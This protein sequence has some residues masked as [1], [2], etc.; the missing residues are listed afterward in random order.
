MRKIY[1]FL[2][3]FVYL[4]ASVSA[5]TIDEFN[6]NIEVYQDGMVK[7]NNKL[8]FDSTEVEEVVYIPIYSPQTLTVKDQEGDLKYATFSG[9]ITIAPNKKIQNYE[10]EVEY[11]TTILTS[12]ENN[13]W[14]IEYEYPPLETLNYNLIK[15]NQIKINLPKGTTLMY[16]ISNSRV[17]VEK[18]NLILEWNPELK[19]EDFVIIEA[20]FLLK[21]TKISYIKDYLLVGS[22]VLL[23]IIFSFF[24]IKYVV[25]KHIKKVSK[26]KQDII[27]ILSEPEKQ[28]ITLLL[29][30][31]DK[32]LAQSKIFGETG[33]SKPTLSRTLKRLEG[34]KII[35]IKPIGNTNLIILHEEF[36][37]K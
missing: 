23:I 35:E 30:T 31:K 33:I 29:N 11:M 14:K 6:T 18:E 19:K 27:D 25:N 15:S 17:F 22:I 21:P 37:K 4:P 8:I 13:K 24:G 9:F 32:K 34:R 20:S 2:L 3:I 16:S 28:V 1:L 26:G 36:V 10:V 5:L 12:K 7:V